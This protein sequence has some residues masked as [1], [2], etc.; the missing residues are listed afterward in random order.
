MS[1]RPKP[2]PN[3]KFCQGMGYFPGVNNGPPVICNCLRNGYVLAYSLHIKANDAIKS[4]GQKTREKQPE[5][6]KI[7]E[8][9]I[10]KIARKYMGIFG[11]EYNG[12]SIMESLCVEIEKL[13]EE[14]QVIMKC[15]GC[16][17]GDS[18]FCVKY[19]PLNK[20]TGGKNV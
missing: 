11:K 13:R 20:P 8:A 14:K 19:C 17:E 7:E 5:V 1:E 2:D 15:A 9:D 6:K 12:A 16:N 18:T 3:C 4:L 10:V